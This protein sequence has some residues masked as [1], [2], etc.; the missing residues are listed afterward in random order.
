M[1]K[2]FAVLALTCAL[3]VSTVAGDIPFDNDPPPPPSCTENCLMSEPAPSLTYYRIARELLQVI[4]LG[5]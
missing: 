2:A 1:K 3:A 5:V 4:V